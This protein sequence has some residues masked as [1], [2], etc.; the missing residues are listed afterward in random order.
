MKPSGTCTANKGGRVILATSSVQFQSKSVNGITGIRDLFSCVAASPDLVIGPNQSPRITHQNLRELDWTRID[1][2]SEEGWWHLY[3]FGERY[4]DDELSH[5]PW[6]D[7]QIDLD[8][9][10]PYYGFR[11]N[12]TFLL[13]DLQRSSAENTARSTG[14]SRNV[15]QNYEASSSRCENFNL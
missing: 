14:R 5:R 7:K 3:P 13:P 8:F 10:L 12:Y 9:F 1:R 15:G 4:F 11:F 6:M 2:R